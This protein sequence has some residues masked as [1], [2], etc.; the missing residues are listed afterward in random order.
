MRRGHHVVE[1]EQRRVGARL[2]DED[3]EAGG[4]DAAVLEGLGERGLVDQAAAGGVDDPHAG[5][6][7]VQGVLAD[8]PHGLGGLRQVDR[9]EVRGGEQRVEVDEPDPELGRDRGLR[10]RVV[11][12]DVHVE[13]LHAGGD[14]LPDLAEADH[15]EGLALDLDAGELLAVPTPGAQRGVGAGDVAGAG[16][17][18]RD[19]LLGGGDDVGGRRVDDHDAAF[20]GGGQLDVVEAHAGAGDDLEFRR[21]LERGGVDGGGGSD[22]HGIG[23]D[24]CGVEGLHVRTVDLPDVEVSGEDLDRSGRERVGNDHDGFRFGHGYL[25]KV[26]RDGGPGAA[27]RRR[28][29]WYVQ[30][31][32]GSLPTC[33]I[34][35]PGTPLACQTP[36]VTAETAR[37]SRGA[38]RFV[39]PAPFQ[40]GNGRTP[41]IAGSGVLMAS[42]GAG[43]AATRSGRLHPGVRPRRSRLRRGPA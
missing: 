3:V 43:N 24:Q 34:P 11:G 2:L 22:D 1:G 26:R 12:D 14:E 32:N 8:D 19:G 35:N 23:L 40:P 25:A 30:R 28:G 4:G 42:R 36:Q 39:R 13:G 17:Q 15:A 33:R 31:V 27:L 6:D 37:T 21:V 5:L 9:D 16:E 38:G 29:Q 18:Q 10:V 7:L 20:G 41:A